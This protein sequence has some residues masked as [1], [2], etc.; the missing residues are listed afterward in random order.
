MLSI[1]T[2]CRMTRYRQR[3][4]VVTLVALLWGAPAAPAVAQ[5]LSGDTFTSGGDPYFPAAGNRGYDVRNYD[6]TLDYTPATR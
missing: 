5:P 6:L 3:A 2:L 1:S 4:V